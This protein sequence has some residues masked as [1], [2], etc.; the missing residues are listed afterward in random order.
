MYKKLT[1]PHLSSPEEVQCGALYSLPVE[2]RKIRPSI[3][4]FQKVSR[5][6]ILQN[7]ISKPVGDA[8]FGCYVVLVVVGSKDK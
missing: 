1:Q 2:Y 7:P 5:R 3:H 6:F 8:S 4:A